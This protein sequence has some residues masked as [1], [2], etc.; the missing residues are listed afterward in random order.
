MEILSL[1]EEN[2]IKDLKNLLRLKKE[3]NYTAINDIRIFFFLQEKETI[4]I[5]YR[6]LRDIEN[7]FGNEDKENYH[8]SVR[9]IIF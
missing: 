9:V 1:T 7:L 8:K 4:E 2:I 5:K 6:I 3:P